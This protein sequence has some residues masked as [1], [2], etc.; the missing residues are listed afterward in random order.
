MKYLIADNLSS[1]TESQLEVMLEA[2]PVWRR[3]RV[4]RFKHFKGRAQSTQAFVL[5]QQLMVEEYGIS[6]IPEFT[7]NAIVQCFLLNI[8]IKTPSGGS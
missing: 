7:Y 6:S 5:L 3:N 4:L 8:H 2:L 1:L